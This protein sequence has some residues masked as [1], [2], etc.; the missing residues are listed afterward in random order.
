MITTVALPPW[1][2][3]GILDDLVEMCRRSATTDVV[4]MMMGIPQADINLEGTVQGLRQFARIKEKLA[5]H[6]VQAG[7]LIQNLLGHGERGEPR[8][9]LTYQR[10]V[11]WDGQENRSCFCPLDREF[12]ARTEH[13]V[14]LMAAAAPAFLLIDDDVRL[15]NHLPARWSC[16]CPL[17][18]AC[19]NQL[20]HRNL[21][22][23]EIFAAM[24]GEGGE[25]KTAREAW[26]KSGEESLINLAQT[27]RR[28]I[29]NVNPELRCGKCLSGGRHLLSTEPLARALAGTTRPMVRLGGAVYLENG[30]K[31]F[32]QVMATLALER[33]LMAGDLEYLCEADTFP[34]TLYSTSCQTLRGYIAGSILAARVDVPYTWIPN[35]TEW[36]RPEWEAYADTL[37]RSVN[38]FQALSLLQ[39]K[40]RWLG[41]TAACLRVHN[42]VPDPQ[43]MPSVETQTDIT[44]G[45]QVC[46]RMGIPFTVNDPEARTVMLNGVSAADLKDDEIRRY[47]AGGLLL[48]GPA[49]WELDRR[50]FADYLGVDVHTAATSLE[51]TEEIA[52]EDRANGP[53]AGMHLSSLVGGPADLMRLAPRSDSTRVLG[54]LA[55]NRW[56]HDPGLSKVAP[57]LTAYINKLGGRVAVYAYSLNATLSMV[58]MNYVRRQQI[59]TLLEWLEGAPLPA[60]AETPA[61]TYFLLARNQQE[62]EYVAAV[63]NL[64]S[65][66][67]EGC[68]NLRWNGSPPQHVLRLDHGGAWRDLGFESAGRRLTLKTPLE[69]MKPLVLR[70]QT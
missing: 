43:H 39:P 59:V 48:D 34:Q 51:V 54:W 30:Y 40:V 35:T 5:S 4:V 23:E 20:A 58:F 33:S 53:A 69:T 62:G 60:L 57:A 9:P 65:D 38:F 13:M 47:L 45:G 68:V 67:V 10:I 36:V 15:D 49:A 7:I 3:P 19:F 18:V 28:A 46:G 42:F 55:R 31:G 26:L 11:G 41:P 24:R 63:F 16:A 2:E 61:D 44:W 64:S 52:T 56:F 22:R 8:S 6:G 17:H 25:A 21:D 12:L 32:A 70:I 29:N 14:Q 50:G 1:R 27:I 37:G 66:T